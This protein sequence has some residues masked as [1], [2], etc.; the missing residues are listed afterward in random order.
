MQRTVLRN[1]NLLD[2]NHP[3]RPGTSVVIEGS[4][5]REIVEDAALKSEAEDRVVDLAGR[6]LMPGLWSSHFH[7]IFSDW[8]PA[9]APMLG[10]DAQ[11]GFMA[12][13]A[14]NNVKRA[15]DSGFTSLICSSSAYN[16]DHALKVAIHRGLIP[17]PR[18]FAC[19]RE[20]M[21]PGD[22]P[23]GSNSSWYMEIGNH[24]IVRR[25]S[26][27]E[28]FRHA[29]REELGRGADIAKVSASAGHGAGPADEIESLNFEEL[30]A[31]ADAAHG[32]GKKVRAHTASKRSIL[33]CAR[34]G[35]DIID[36]ADRLDEEGIE[37]I[38]AADLSLAPTLLFPTRFLG[39]LQGLLD[40]G[41]DIGA[42]GPDVA[43]RE[44][45]Q[46]RIDGGRADFENMCAMLPEANRAGLRLLVGD[47]YGVTSIPHGDYSAEFELYVDKL[48]IPALD[49]IRWA[50][51]NGAETMNVYAETGSVEVGKLADLIV[52]DGDPTRNISLLGNPEATVAIL[53]KGIFYKDVL[54]PEASA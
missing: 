2:G 49:V 40:Q 41:I 24:G 17:G 28:G 21:T 38:L 34:A 52:I 27:P 35:V 25:C 48:G 39:F 13:V 5:I 53:Q 16:I 4:S 9:Q 42:Q 37:A 44:E 50:T 47:D 32:R 15:L 12:L 43:S 22:Q 46:A 1:A 14:Q 19:T 20:L 26:G 18:L 3:A 54:S 8:A 6:T 45:F 30:R 51:R 7:T 29:V 33:D 10:L 31:A 23:D 11:P 36:H